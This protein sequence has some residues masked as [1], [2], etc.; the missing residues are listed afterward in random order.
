MVTAVDGDPADPSPSKLIDP[1][2]ASATR[3]T[4]TAVKL[5]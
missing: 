1:A 3:S 4:G 5:R 2:I